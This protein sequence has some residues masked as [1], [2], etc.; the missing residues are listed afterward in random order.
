MRHHGGVSPAW[1]I[2]YDELEP[3]Y[4]QAEHLYQVHGQRGERSDR[5]AGERAVSATRRSATSRA[6]SSWSTTSTRSGHRPFHMPVGVML[7]EQNPQ[8]EP[9]H[10]LRHLRRL[11]VPRERQGRRA[12]RLRR[13]GARAP[14]RRR[15]LT[16]AYVTRLETERLGPR[17]DERRTSSAN[18]ERE[19]YSADVVVVSCGAINS[20]ALLLRSANDRHPNGLANGSGVVGRHYMCHINSVLLAVSQRPEPD[21]LPEDARG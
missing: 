8:H 15:S 17:G 19:T 6:S 4:T 3:Y 9:L 10:P 18:G 16:G 12:G 20:A 21:A 1:P 7:D 5:A 2:T 11:P 14:E 13:P